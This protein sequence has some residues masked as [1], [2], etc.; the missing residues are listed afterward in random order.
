M[1]DQHDGN[2]QIQSSSKPVPVRLDRLD[3]LIKYLEG[4]QNSSGC[5]GISNNSTTRGC[6]SVDMAVRDSDT[7]GSILERLALLENRLFQLCLE[8]EASSTSSSSVAHSSENT[9]YRQESTTDQ[10]NSIRSI[11][12]QNFTYDGN[13]HEQQSEQLY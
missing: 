8:I 3:S 9:C 11:D 7:K 13:F 2:I 5:G 1:G 4:K 10:S 12:E 6:M